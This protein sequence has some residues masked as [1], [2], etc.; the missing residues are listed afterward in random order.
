MS[1]KSRRTEGEMKEEEE[2]EVQKRGHVLQ[3]DSPEAGEIVN[4]KQ[5]RGGRTAGRQ[6]G[7]HRVRADLWS[8]R[9]QDPLCR[10]SSQ[11]AHHAPPLPPD[12]GTPGR[13]DECLQRG[14]QGAYGKGRE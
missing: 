5:K 10:R 6:T 3:H 9:W 7:R 12:E 11:W 2:K 1:T 13:N 8:A 4:R 14:R